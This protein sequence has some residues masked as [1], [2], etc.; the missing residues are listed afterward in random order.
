MD[1]IT[2]TTESDY[3]L[4]IYSANWADEINVGGSSLFKRSEWEEKVREVQRY[5]E[6]SSEAYLCH[7]IGTNES[8]EYHNFSRWLSNYT[9]VEITQNQATIMLELLTNYLFKRSCEKLFFFAEIDDEDEDEDEDDD[10]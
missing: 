2:E 3:V 9:V 5:Y 10:D 1:T 4:V 6:S 7:N 8:I